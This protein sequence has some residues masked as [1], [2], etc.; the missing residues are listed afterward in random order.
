ME[1]GN[2]IKALRQSRGVTQET[3][4]QAL[5]VSAQAVSKWETGG[6]LP[7]IA[8]LPQLS[9]YFGVSIDELFALSD[10]T[11][12]ERIQNMLWEQR[13]LEPAMV[14]RERGFLLDLCRRE[15]EKA[16]GWSLLAELELHLAEEH[17]GRAAEYA[18]AALERDPEVKDAHDTLVMA[19][20]G[21]VADWNVANHHALIDWYKG[22]LEKNPTCRAGYLWLMDQLIDDF[23]FD[24]AEEA[25]G[26]MEALEG[27]DFRT[28]LYRGVL[29]WYRGNRE[30]A[31]AIWE[32][33]EMGKDKEWLKAFSMGDFL[34]RAG[35]YEAAQAHYRKAV[36]LQP[37]PRYVD[38]L[39]SIAQICELRKDW[40][41][42]IAAHREAID[43][44]AKDWGTTS[45]EQVDG[46]RRE[47]ARLREKEQ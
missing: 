44:L 31:W 8:L 37:P 25:L 39:D 47:I 13:A 4:A 10:E 33:M 16:R 15:P 27:D 12:L 19:M 45:G 42:A 1:L 3:L 21:K 11:R 6:A 22:F 38:I 17:Q 40:D 29:E 32:K 9:A 23:R 18:K 20:N 36:E 35:E 7:D 46:H 34:A 28:Q 43:I 2:Q 26:K 41:G 24:E 14:D 5:G 30:K